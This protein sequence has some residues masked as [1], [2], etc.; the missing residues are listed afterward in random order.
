MSLNLIDDYHNRVAFARQQ[1][2]KQEKLVNTY[3]LL[4]LGVFV[5]FLV[6]IYV[7]VSFNNILF[8]VIATAVL[9]I[10]FNRLVSQQSQFERDKIYY[11]CYEAVCQNELNS[12]A[13]QAN[14]YDSGSS[15]MND[16]HAYT[17][18]LDVFGSGSLLQL[19]NRA[20]SPAGRKLLAAWLI[21]PA[22]RNNILLRQEAVKELAANN[23][24]KLDVQAKMLFA[25]KEEGLQLQKLLTYLKTPVQLSNEY[26]LNLYTKVVPF[27]TVGGVVLSVFFPV[28]RYITVALLTFNNRLVSAQS[29]NIQKADLIAGKIGEG[30]S[31]YAD[32]FA[33]IENH[34][35]QSPL[36]INLAQQIRAEQGQT[37]SAQIRQLSGLV[38]RLNQRLNMVMN[39]LLNAFFIWNIR[40]VIAIENWK[41]NNHENL[42][43]AF[44][45]IAE[46]EAL[47]SMSGLH[48]NYPDWC[49]PEIAEGAGYTL[50]AETIAH[51]LIKSTVRVANDYELNNTRKVDIVT[52]SN[53]AGKS[54]FLRTLG[55]N[56]V[57]ALCGAPVCARSM[58]VS[59][60]QL[61]SYMR[62]KDSL[63]ESTSTFKAELDRLQMLLTAV[64]QENNILFLVDEMLRGTN[65]VDKYLGSKAVIE[66]LIV[67]KGVGL[68]ATHDLQLAELEQQYPDYIRNFY[69]DI[70]VQH[71]EMLF[72]YK[73][74]HGACKTF[75]ASMLLKQI[76]IH[77]D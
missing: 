34:A 43:K 76:G 61:F 22:E 58:R 25:L 39:F 73:L 67:Y 36:C 70:Q 3:S 65:S 17:A 59:V 15:F 55:I 50:T 6:C 57:L 2:A 52:G 40:Q 60:V 62:I 16:K 7:A 44:N 49:F 13:T 1:A 42:E 12:I 9:S 5:A 28:A 72:D 32:V 37:V 56:T 33:E 18:D 31:G 8:F 38:N 26:W 46:F 20:A 75:N 41:R 77:I 30:L 53:M 19:M 35:W 24:W 64:Q 11:N 29:K 51:P 69:F 10:V 48:I 54:T 14:I 47:M 63:N 27:L 45:V 4:R 68:V 74:K 23:D 66:Q 71:G 21:Q